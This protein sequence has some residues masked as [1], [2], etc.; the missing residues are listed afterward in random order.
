M[1]TVFVLPWTADSGISFFEDITAPVRRTGDRV[2]FWLPCAVPESL[3][4]AWSPL[5]DAVICGGGDIR[6]IS[7]TGACLRWL[8][9]LCGERRPDLILFPGTPAGHELAARLAARL[10]RDCFPETRALLREGNRLFARRK[11]CGSN[12][13]LD[14][15]IREYPAIITVTGKKTVQDGG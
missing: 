3:P 7:H 9:E 6:D 5:P 4:Q 1:N 11:V 10:H 8:E 12:L 13:D 15:E 14:A 2:E